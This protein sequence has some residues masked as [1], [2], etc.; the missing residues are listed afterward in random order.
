M[1]C[2]AF[3]LAAYKPGVKLEQFDSKRKRLQRS[4]ADVRSK[5]D[6][7][8]HVDLVDGMLRKARKELRGKRA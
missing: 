2:D 1:Y 6:A 8:P 7:A 5:P 4:Y 3:K